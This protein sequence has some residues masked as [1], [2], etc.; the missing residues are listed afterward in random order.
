MSYWIFKTEPETFSIDDLA[1]LASTTWDGVRNYQVRNM[2]RDDIKIGD[3]VFVYHSNAGDQTGIVGT[4]TVSSKA[5][6]DMLAFDPKSDYYDPKSKKD[7][8]TWL[9][10][11]IKFKSKAKNPIPLAQMKTNKKLEG[12]R[13]LE[14]GTR[15]SIT[16]VSAKHARVI[17]TAILS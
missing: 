17:N 16:P 8:P 2:I 14:K 4:A 11:D 12:L 1:R 7:T 15:L 6:P 3:V 10:I 13:I 5:H 9:A